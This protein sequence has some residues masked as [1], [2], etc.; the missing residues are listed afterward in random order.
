MLELVKSIFER[1]KDEDVLERL[2][3][4]KVPGKEL[5]SIESGSSLDLD[6]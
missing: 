3:D 2:P 5:Q 6:M 4:G 1:S